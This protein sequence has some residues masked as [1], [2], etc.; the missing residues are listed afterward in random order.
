MQEIQTEIFIN[1]PI[2]KVWAVLTDLHAYSAWNPFICKVEGNLQLD[3]PLTVTVQPA[4]QKPMSFRS[5]IDSLGEYEFSWLGGV[6][7][8]GIF[9]GLHR[10]KLEKNANNQVKF[11]HSERFSGILHWPILYMIG[12]STR[13]GFV[14]MNQ[15]LKERCETES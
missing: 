5:K 7:I 1:A 2:E 10:F 15:A 3:S 8:P 9:K 14:N 12:K 13:E 6:G 11:I 4:G